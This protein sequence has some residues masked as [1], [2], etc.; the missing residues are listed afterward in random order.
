MFIADEPPIGDWHVVLPHWAIS[1][2]W[3]YPLPDFQKRQPWNGWNQRQTRHLPK[4]VVCSVFVLVSGND[5]PCLK[6]D[7]QWS[8]LFL[9]VTS[10]DSSALC[11]S[12]IFWKSSRSNEIVFIHANMWLAHHEKEYSTLLCGDAACCVF[13]L[14]IA[15]MTEPRLLLRDRLTTD[16]LSKSTF[17]CRSLAHL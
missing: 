1:P 13:C 2:D 4:A 10:E 15:T 14:L 6:Q 8:L 12:D 7:R 5:S 9:A 17:G 11:S 3:K 16:W